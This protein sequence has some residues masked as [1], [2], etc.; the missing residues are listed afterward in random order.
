MNYITNLKTNIYLCDESP[1]ILHKTFVTTK[2]LVTTTK[3][4]RCANRHKIFHLIHST[5]QLK[6]LVVH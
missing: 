5:D 1:K 6:K 2:T 3:H 4:R